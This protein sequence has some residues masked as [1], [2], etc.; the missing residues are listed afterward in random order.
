MLFLLGNPLLCNCLT[1]PLNRWL[2]AQLDIPEEWQNVRCYGPG[3]LEKELLYNLTEEVLSC[4]RLYPIHD[5]KYKISSDIEFREFEVKKSGISLQWLINSKEDIADFYLFIR[6]KENDQLKPPVTVFEKFLP[7]HIRKT[8]IDKKE[9]ME[10]IKSR[11]V[12]VKISGNGE[13]KGEY[14]LCLAAA[15]SYGDLRQWKDRQ[16]RNL[17]KFDFSTASLKGFNMV[18]VF[19]VLMFGFVVR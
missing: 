11:K 12:D 9:V 8:I 15:D 10:Y 14:E 2:H 7:Y 18:L 6:G 5:D 13:M 3:Y 19:V 1:R 17:K 16:C 4:P